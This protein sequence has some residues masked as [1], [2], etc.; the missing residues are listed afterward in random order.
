LALELSPVVSL[1]LDAV[2]LDSGEYGSSVVEL[3]VS[4]EVDDVVVK[5]FPYGA[6]L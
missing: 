1:L 2:L 5:L 3:V 6:C 4:L